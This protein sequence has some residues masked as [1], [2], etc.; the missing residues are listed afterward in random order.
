LRRVPR[1]L[2][3]NAVEFFV[4]YYD[5]YQPEAY[6]PTTDTYI[7]KD[8][9]INEEIERLRHSATS[10]VMER[11]DVWWSR[12]SRASSASARPSSTR[13]SRCACTGQR[14]DRD[15]ILEQLVRRCSSPQ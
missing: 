6:L 7:E 3:G 9:Q 15:E 5:Y 12:R 8:S 4:S 11:R 10:G 14:I 1:V 13:R 2:P